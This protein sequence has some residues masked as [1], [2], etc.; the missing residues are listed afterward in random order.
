MAYASFTFW[1]LVIVLTAGGV[2]R[3]WA[4]LVRPKV[5]NIVLLPGTLVAQV[6]HVLGLLVTG[7]TITNNSLVASD[8]SGEPAATTNPNPRIPI[9]G[10]IVI[11]LLPLLACGAC[12]YAVVSMLGMPVL[13][14]IDQSA[15]GPTLPTSMPQIWQML[16][17]QISLM[18]SLVNAVGATNLAAWQTWLF[19]YLLVCLSIRI[20][21]VRGNLRGSLG[22]ILVLGVVAAILGSFWDT[23]SARVQGGWALLS[24]TVATLWL[25][26]S[27]SLITRGTIALYR[28][29]R[30][31]D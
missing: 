1:L 24:L 21:P 6:G 18:E 5:F 28:L 3:L 17:D 19:L 11:G 22:A 20:A 2:Q 8:E 10:P 7:A 29:L 16:R 27:L 9:V 13:R 23:G 25:L 12:V 30:N 15:V 26:M 4:G 14:G 31:R